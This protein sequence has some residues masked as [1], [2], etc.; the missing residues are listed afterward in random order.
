MSEWEV[1]ERVPFIGS[2]L[3]VWVNGQVRT[4]KRVA[5]SQSLTP[6]TLV[7]TDCTHPAQNVLCHEPLVQGW[8]VKEEKA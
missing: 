6:G 3:E 4:A 8:R 2:E 5:W 7:F 1:Q